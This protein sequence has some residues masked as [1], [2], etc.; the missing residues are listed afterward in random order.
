MRLG[1]ASVTTLTVLRARS[2]VSFLL[3]LEK[4]REFTQYD[5][6][7]PSKVCPFPLTKITTCRGQQ[8]GRHTS[9]ELARLTSDVLAT[10]R[11][12]VVSYEYE[13]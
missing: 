6:P 9:L 1:D 5:G 2:E 7:F 13:L 10:G 4:W 12:A 3:L 11:S 8:L